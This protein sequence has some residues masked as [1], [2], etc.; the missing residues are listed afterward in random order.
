MA[1]RFLNYLPSNPTLV[2]RVVARFDALGIN[3]ER[4]QEIMAFL[5][6][7][8]IKDKET[9]EH[10]FR[11]GLLT[12]ALC[13]FIH[14]DPV[15]GFYAGM[16]HDIGKQQIRLTTLQKTDGWTPEDSEEM[17]DHV[18]NGYKILRDHFDFTAEVIIWHHRFQPNKYPER[19][20]PP[21]H[22]YSEGTRV[23]IPF[24]GRLL[25]LADIF[26]AFHRLNGK[27]ERESLTGEEIKR[28]ML[29]YNPDEKRLI[30]EAYKAGIFTTDIFE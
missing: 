25:S 18:M 10:G 1:S 6:P 30:A 7:L 9:C 14:L 23:M 20:P 2:E 16:L 22:D 3:P 24:L 28:R 5:Q 4:R 13:E 26:D 12:S 17:K 19:V 15:A 11:V 27:H 29:K 21:L 8:K